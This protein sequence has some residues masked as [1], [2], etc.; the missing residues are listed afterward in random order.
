[1]SITDRLIE[2]IE[3]SKISQREISRRA[4]AQRE[5]WLSDLLRAWRGGRRG[6]EPTI[7]TLQM[8]ARGLGVSLGELLGAD[9]LNQKEDARS[10]SH[11]R[12]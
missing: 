9:L 1:M 11:G 7:S 3:N 4:G 2:V 10:S 6:K 8:L 5:T 12:P